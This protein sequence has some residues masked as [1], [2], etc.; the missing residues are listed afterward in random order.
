M[1]INRRMD[2]LWYSHMM[3]FYTRVKMKSYIYH[4]WINLKNIMLRHKSK[5]WKDMCNMLFNKVFKMPNTL[6]ILFTEIH[7]L[8]LGG[9]DKKTPFSCLISE[10]VEKSITSQ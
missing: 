2:Q 3:E 10:L 7:I 6:Y 8:Y 9:S 5:L 4:Q 1:S